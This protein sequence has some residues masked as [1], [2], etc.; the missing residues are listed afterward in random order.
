MC[1]DILIK[2]GKC[3]TMKNGEIL[4]WIAVEG[5]KIAAIGKNRDYDNL[6]TDDTLV[7]DAKGNTVLPGFIDSHFHLVLTA[8]NAASLDLGKAKKFDDIGRLIKEAA[9]KYPGKHIR[10]IHLEVEQLKEKEF[11]NRAI[12]DKYC[13]NAAVS[14]HSA[15]YQVSILNTYAM[16]YFKIPFT[17][18]GIEID[19]KQMTT[20]IFRKQANAILFSNTLKDVNENYRK[21]VVD[22]IINKLLS[23][24][25]TTIN[26]MEGGRM[27]G[28]IDRDEDAEFIFKYGKQFPIDMELFYPTMDIDKIKDMGLKRIGGVLY[29][30]GTIG[31]RTA[32]L[33]FEY[34]DA[35]GTDGILCMAQD[36]INEFVLNCYK[37][38]LQLALFTLGDR[39]IE[40]ALIAHEYAL[41]KTGIT[42][43]RHRLEHVELASYDQMKRA[44]KLGII[45]SMQPTYEAYWGGKGKM[46]EQRLGNNYMRT[47]CF[48]E[49]I[50]S[51][52]TICGGSDSDVT[53]PNP[54]RGIHSAVNHPVKQHSID[55]YEALKMYTCNGAYALFE[56]DKKGTLEVGKIADIIILNNDIMSINKEEIEKLKVLVT[57]KSGELLYNML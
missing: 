40:A 56:E 38:N 41:G 50:D 8:L 53:E 33:T 39:A 13:N 15:D 21:D 54:I 25:I 20:G 2:N 11:P 9:A 27:C 6:I 26:A 51:G 35:P 24:G 57:I 4:D 10:G 45:F 14:L 32:A 49:I 22:N 47:N 18:D 43:L 42:G 36:D 37:N 19:E 5:G 55:V 31:G 44:A 30:D 3:M 34:A 1:T 52:V 46:Y 23:N 16:L 7:I 17:T 28:G 12:L 29:L 48:R